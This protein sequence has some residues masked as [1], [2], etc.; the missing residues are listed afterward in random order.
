[1]MFGLFGGFSLPSGPAPLTLP[2]I[3]T[4]ANPIMMLNT[5]TLEANFLS[6][7]LTSSSFV[8]LS[9]ISVLKSAFRTPESSFLM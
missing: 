2:C 1:M 6:M 8:S 3:V 9:Y 5:K 4:R 7:F